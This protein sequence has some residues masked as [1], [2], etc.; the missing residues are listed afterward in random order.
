MKRLHSIGVSVIETMPEMRIAAVIVIANSRNNR[1]RMPLMNRI[2]MNTAASDTVIDRIVKPIS[3]D[4]FSAASNGCSPCSMCRTMFSS[5]TIASSTTNPIER[6]SAIID[7][8]SSVK[9]S[10]AMTANVPRMENGSASAGMIV[11]DPLCRNR[12]MT[13]TTSASVIAIVH[14][15]SVNASRM[16]FD[17]SPRIVRCTEGGSSASNA[18]SRFRIA[19]VTAIVLL[20]G[21][22]IT[23]RL[24]ARRGAPVFV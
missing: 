7:R 1:P 8:L 2:G 17:R 13:A 14:W 3:F 11:A 4:P 15:M 12:K 20:P 10:T 19:S 21:C 16:F 23:W 6:I 24:I 18:G 9:P 5:M 22:F